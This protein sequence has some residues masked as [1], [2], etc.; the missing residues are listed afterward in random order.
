[1]CEIFAKSREGGKEVMSHCMGLG[2]VC[3]IN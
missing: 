1:M 2:A 3:G